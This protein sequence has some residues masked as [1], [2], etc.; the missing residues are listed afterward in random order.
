LSTL[1]IIAMK[2]NNSLVIAA[3]LLST[4]TANAWA[5]VRSPYPRKPLPPDNVIVVVDDRRDWVR[6]TFR[7]SK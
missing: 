3:I 1:Y 4:L 5:L 7:D 2:T 6:S